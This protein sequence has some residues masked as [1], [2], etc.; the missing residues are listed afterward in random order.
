PGPGRGGGGRPSVPRTGARVGAML[1]GAGDDPERSLGRVP[2]LW[3]EATV[4][5][6]AVNAVMA[7]CRPAYL[8][9]L[10][11]AMEA[12]CDP[13]FN[14]YSIQ[15]TTHPVAPLLIVS[16][17]IVGAI[18]LNAG[19][20]VFGPGWQANA[21]IGRA[22][23][24][25]LMNVGGAW[26]GDGDMATQGQ[27]GKYSYC[28]AENQ[29]ANPWAPLHVDLGFDPAASAVTVFGGEAPHNVNDHVSK[30]AGGVLGV[31][32]QSMATLG[33]NAKWIMPDASYVVA[34]GP[35]HA[36]TI[37][38]DGFSKADVRRFLYETARL[39]LRE[40]RRGGMW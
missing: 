35:E 18:G 38:A 39:P 26:P 30:T 5:K 32:A 13:A 36:A 22:I 14:L 19:P 23:R 15:A 3:A 28:I 10:L 40:Y 16:G 29:A 4:E 31:V 25:V 24:L 34:L 20:G 21:T 33:S 11:A 1:G 6:V 27:P 37:A 17:P 2:P 7:G 8:P 12:L 9:V